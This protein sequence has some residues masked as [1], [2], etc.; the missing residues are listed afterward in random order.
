VLR[1]MMV[2]MI[3]GIFQTP[4]GLEYRVWSPVT[5]EIRVPSW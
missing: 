1:F 5:T 2:M 4:S 3:M